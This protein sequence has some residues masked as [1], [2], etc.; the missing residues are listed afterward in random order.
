MSTPPEVTVVD[1]RPKIINILLHRADGWKIPFKIRFGGVDTDLSGYILAAQVREDPDSEEKTDLVTA[2]VEQTT[3]RF[4]IAQP[5]A[6]VI[7]YYDIEL[8][9]EEGV[10]RTYIAGRM[11]VDKDVTKT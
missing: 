5:A 4:T 6:G 2:W 3:G 9:D 10:P 1:L 8:K 7:G 11:T